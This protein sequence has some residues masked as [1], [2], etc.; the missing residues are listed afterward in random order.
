MIA[1]FIV[2][3]KIVV[4]KN[5]LRNVFG[6]LGDR[7]PSQ[8]TVNISSGEGPYTILAVCMCSIPTRRVKEPS[9]FSWVHKKI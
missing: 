1:Y 3:C 5:Y 9:T 7:V 8:I 6:P 2:F 4:T